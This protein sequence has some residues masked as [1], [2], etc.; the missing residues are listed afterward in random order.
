M[1]YINDYDN[2]NRSDRSALLLMI[3]EYAALV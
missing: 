2:D 1:H 3:A